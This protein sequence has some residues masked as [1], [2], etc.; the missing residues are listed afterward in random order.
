[1]NGV[2]Q[3][4]EPISL[5]YTDATMVLEKANT[6]SG[7]LFNLAKGEDF[8]MT[9]VIVPPADPALA[10]SALKATRILRGAPKMRRVLS[11]RELN[12]F[13]PEIERDLE[14]SDKEPQ[15]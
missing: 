14:A 1:V 12:D 9:G 2:P 15:A 3:V 6:W 13:I 4:I 8:R 5:D 10:E 11:L 7:R